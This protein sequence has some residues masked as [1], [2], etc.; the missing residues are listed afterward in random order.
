M[1]KI[2]VVD[3]SPTIRAAVGGALAYKKAHILEAGTAV[4]AVKLFEQE[5]PGLVFLDIPL[6]GYPPRLRM[7]IE[8]SADPLFRASRM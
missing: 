3:G 1:H 7:V 5:R 2:L 4:E 6:S 8:A